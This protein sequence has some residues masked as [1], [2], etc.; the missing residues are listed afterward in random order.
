MQRGRR[1]DA[2]FLPHS[3]KKITRDDFQGLSS[4][5]R[6]DLGELFEISCSLGVWCL[7]FSL[8]E[9]AIWPR[10]WDTNYRVCQAGA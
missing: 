9:M 5:C 10:R 8:M 3:F 4:I 2:W 1:K 7:A 6:V